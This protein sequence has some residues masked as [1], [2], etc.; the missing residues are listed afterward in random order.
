MRTKFKFIDKE[1]QG[2]K[3]AWV[4]MRQWM[5]GLPAFN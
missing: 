3:Y 4:L 2:S 1:A 5:F